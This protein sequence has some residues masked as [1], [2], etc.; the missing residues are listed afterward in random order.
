[1]SSGLAIAFDDGHAGALLP[2]FGHHTLHRHA[3][4]A[5]EL[6][7][8]RVDLGELRRIEQRPVQRVDADDDREGIRLEVVDVGLH[9]SRVA[10]QHGMC[11]HLHEHET[12][13]QRVDV[14]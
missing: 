7:G 2:T 11:A 10:H 4:G 8:V 13:G 9:V 5:G 12:G 1:M 3:P 6:E 14:I